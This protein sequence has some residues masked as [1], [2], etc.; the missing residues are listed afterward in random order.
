MPCPLLVGCRCGAPEDIATSSRCTEHNRTNERWQDRNPDKFTYGALG[1]LTVARL[2][3]QKPTP[4][5]PTFDGFGQGRRREAAPAPTFNGF[6]QL[7]AAGPGRREGAVSITPGRPVACARPPG[8]APTIPGGSWPKP[9]KVGVRPWR[10]AAASPKPSKVGASE[11]SIRTTSGIL[12]AAGLANTI[13]RP[14]S[15]LWGQPPEVNSD[16]GGG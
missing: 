9:S 12:G 8:A 6:G 16:C 5:A 15:G 14:S 13:A 3:P 11:G 7:E 2:E 1:S 4:P 10:G